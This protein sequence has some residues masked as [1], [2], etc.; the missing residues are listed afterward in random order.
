MPPDTDI[1]STDALGFPSGEGLFGVARLDRRNRFVDARPNLCEFL[2]FTA[3]EFLHMSL[4]DIVH[5]DDQRQL[6][7][8]LDSFGRAPSGG[9]SVELQVVPKHGAPIWAACQVLPFFAPEISDFALVVSALPGFSQTMAALRA[10]EARYKMLLSNLAGVAYRLVPDGQGGFRLDYVSEGTRDLFGVAPE[11]LLSG[12]IKRADIVHPD[13]FDVVRAGTLRVVTQQVKARNVFRVR[14]ADGEWRWVLETCRGV[15]T[16]SGQIEAI[17][18]FLTDIHE[19]KLIEERLRESERALHKSERQHDAL[20]SNLVGVAFRLHATDTELYLDYVSD[21]VR[22]LFGIEPEAVLRNEIALDHVIER[23]DRRAMRDSIYAARNAGTSSRN[24]VRGLQPDGSF[25]WMVVTMRAVMEDDGTNVV[26]GLIT[27]IHEQKETEER[28]HRREQ[29]LRE[30]HELVG[31]GR[32]EHDHRTGKLIWSDETYR[33][34]GREPGTVHDIDQFRQALHPDDREAEAASFYAS[35][36]DDGPYSAFHRILRPDGEVRYIAERGEISFDDEGSPLRTVGTTLDIT[37]LKRAELALLE[38]QAFKNALLESSDFAVVACDADGKLKMFNSAAREWHGLDAMSIPPEQWPEHYTF[39]GA[40]GK[41]Q[42]KPHA[43]PLARALSGEIVRDAEVSIVLPGKPPRYISCNGAPLH[44]ASG[45]KLGA[46][47]I[48][49]DVTRQ[50]LTEANLRQRDAILSAVAIAAERLL[51]TW[52]WE[53]EI[54]LILSTLGQAMHAGRAYVVRAHSDQNQ[55]VITSVLHEWAAPNVEPAG[56]WTQA[57]GFDMIAA[58]LGHW[59]ERM[60]LGGVMQTRSRDFLPDEQAVMEPAGIKAIITLPIFVHGNWWGI[61]GFDDCE[62]DRHWSLA[63]QEALRAAANTIASAIERR[64]QQEDR[65][66]R[67]VAEEAS[68]AK[69]AFLATMS[70]EIRTPMNAIIGLSEV[71]NQSVLTEEQSDLLN[72]MHDAGR[73]LLYLIDDILDIS[74]IEAGQVKLL[75]APINLAETVD[76]VVGSLI[77]TAAEKGVVLHAFVAPDLPAVLMIDGLRLRQVIYNLL[78]NAIKFS[79]EIAGRTGRVELRVDMDEGAQDPLRVTVRDNGIGMTEEMM[80]RVFEP[81]AQGDSQLTRRYGGTGLGLAITRRIVSMMGGRVSVFSTPDQGSTFTLNLPL[82]PVASQTGKAPDEPL[83]GLHCRVHESRGYIAQDIAAYLRHAGASVDIARSQ[84]AEGAPDGVS[85]VITGEHPAQGVSVPHLVI[86]PGRGRLTRPRVLGERLTA[87][88]GAGLSFNRLIEAARLAV[89]RLSRDCEEVLAGGADQGGYGMYAGLLPILVAEDDPMN[90]K[91]IQRQLALLRLNAEFAGNGRKALEMA[92]TGRYALLLS[93]LH[94][95]EMDGYALARALREEGVQAHGAPLP[96][97]A[98]TADARQEVVDAVHGAGMDGLLIKPVTLKALDAALRPW[99]V[100][101]AAVARDPSASPAE[102]TEEPV[103]DLA[104]LTARIGDD[105]EM[106]HEFLG[107]FRDQMS[108]MATQITEAAM[109]RDLR[110]I[111]ALAHRLKSS[112]R[113]IG[114]MD[115]GA[116]CARIE[117]VCRKED[118]DELSPLLARFGK[119]SAAVGNAIT[120]TIGNAGHVRH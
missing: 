27:D 47:V 100:E 83:A 75:P 20:L 14:G 108:P 79:A 94:M 115:L 18:G 23:E 74:K 59:A 21:G 37:E 50:R 118:V 106:Q 103:L 13:D 46:M 5:P 105:E 26:E 91:V 114:A 6:Q 102:E 42:L 55:R 30:A 35:L 77:S 12:A 88:D 90:Q 45:H 67:V 93:D 61:L 32:W 68:Q 99:L 56:N 39:F 64:R 78:G 48:M 17:E 25:R 49:R 96:I 112:S 116:V 66:A 31:L 7:E 86:E 72:A 51:T 40:D 34:F 44:D 65:L 113:A 101:N 107:A 24:V 97:L 104:E 85:L 10:S 76:A 80:D 4:L 60:R 22:D 16:P 117:E 73:H 69:S 36:T 29:E 58:G 92:R 109:V 8:S 28:L 43:A 38:E 89:G 2:G 120:R 19:Q 87:L 1:R 53:Q 81:F 110:Q 33:I 95:P 41:R 119:S 52:D 9:F 111:G 62:T 82:D 11:D 98:L 70:H 57:K 3:E 84:G 63:E 15:Y 71:L 54:G